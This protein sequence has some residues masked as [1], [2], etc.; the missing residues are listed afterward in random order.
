AGQQRQRA[1]AESH[2]KTDEIEVGPSHERLLLG[3]AGVFSTSISRS[4]NPGLSR[5]VLSST[6]HMRESACLA[7]LSRAQWSSGSRLNRSAPLTSQRSNLSSNAPTSE[8]SSFW[9]PSGSST[10]YPG[11]TLKKRANNM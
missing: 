8:I 11:C 3:L 1:E 10:R 4:A 5:M 6:R 2:Q 9:K 7:I